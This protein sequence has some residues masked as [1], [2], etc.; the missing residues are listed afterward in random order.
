[1]NPSPGVIPAVPER[2]IE[3]G[4]RLA[5]ALEFLRDSGY[6]D[7]R[8]VRDYIGQCRALSDKARVAR[9]GLSQ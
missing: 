9:E 6:E 7:Y 1:M 8:F 2:S 4:N 5:D 3:R